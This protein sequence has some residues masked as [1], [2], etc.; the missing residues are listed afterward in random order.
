[1]GGNYPNICKPAEKEAFSH[2]ILRSDAPDAKGAWRAVNMILCSPRSGAS[3]SYING[4]LP[5]VVRKHVSSVGDKD[6]VRRVARSDAL[7]EEIMAGG[8]A[9]DGELR[10]EREEIYFQYFANEACVREVRLSFLD[11]KW[12]ISEIGEACD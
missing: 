7:V 6:T 1:M 5:K 10:T 3:R 12:L 2:A 8:K 11:R 4:L 9:W